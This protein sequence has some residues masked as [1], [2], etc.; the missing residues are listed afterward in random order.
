MQNQ[1]SEKPP[2]DRPAAQETSERLTKVSGDYPRLSSCLKA[3]AEAPADLDFQRERRKR[4]LARL[5]R[6]VNGWQSVLDYMT[7]DSF[8]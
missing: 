1:V 3:P 2:V 5:E 7:P 6:M 8:P 4:S